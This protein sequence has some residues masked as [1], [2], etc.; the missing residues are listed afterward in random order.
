M[1]KVWCALVLAASIG[2]SADISAHGWGLYGG[3]GY[4]SRFGLGFYFGPPFAGYRYYSPYWQPY[5]PSPYYTYPPAVVTVPS[6]PPVYI[7][8]GPSRPAS[9][10][11]GGYWYYCADPNG[12][13]P[14]IKEC[15]EEWQPVPAQPPVTR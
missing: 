4:R 7:E 12:Y 6:Q 11:S 13:Y 5:Y 1:K 9:D 8:K 3:H 15:R 10:G 2:A 14:Y